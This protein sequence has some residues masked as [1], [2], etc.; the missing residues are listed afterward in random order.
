M[1]IHSYIRRLAGNTCHNLTE[2]FM[3]S[4][5]TPVDLAF[6]DVAEEGTSES[7]A[8]ADH[9][10]GMPNQ[11]SFVDNLEDVASLF[12]EL[13]ITASATATDLKFVNV[14]TVV[15]GGRD[16]SGDGL[17]GYGTVDTPTSAAVPSSNGVWIQN[18]SGGTT[19]TQ[20]HPFKRTRHFAAR[21]R[22]VLQAATELPNVR[23]A[24]GFMRSSTNGD[25]TTITDGVYFLLS[26]D[27]TGAGNYFLVAQNNGSTTSVDTTV[28][29]RRDASNNV[30]FDVFRI[31]YD[32]ETVTGYINGTQ[33]ASLDTNV[34]P[35][36]RKLAGYG[37]WITNNSAVVRT[38]VS[39]FFVW[40]GVRN[41]VE[42]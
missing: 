2:S 40:T 21:V 20:V 16:D 41:F 7:F 3:P 19:L 28:A 31:T 33:V 34:P 22:P 12:H 38:L 42:T 8:R 17:F 10:H 25:V 30:L 4:F 39:D 18:A 27:A 36:S 5:G 29:P 15:I 14:G 1:S 13:V 37:A 23:V 35:A 6:G 9:R 32:G 26:T 24:V 11:D